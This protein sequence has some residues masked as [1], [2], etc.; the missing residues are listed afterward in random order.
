MHLLPDPLQNGKHLHDNPARDDH[1]IA[2][3]RT[4]AEHFRSKSS[5][6]VSAGTRRH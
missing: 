5:Q 3:S 1:Q 2:L 6:V 4:E